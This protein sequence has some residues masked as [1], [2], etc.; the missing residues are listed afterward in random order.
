MQ[1]KSVLVM[2]QTE[3]YVAKLLDE[4]L[5]FWM[6]ECLKTGRRPCVTWI[7]ITSVAVKV[8]V[9]AVET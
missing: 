6:L 3:A 7:L 1:G 9:R 5:A 4:R 8:L 2:T